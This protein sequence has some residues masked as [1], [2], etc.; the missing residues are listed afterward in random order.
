M[1][2]PGR[3]H[4]EPDR[5]H[6]IPDG[7]GEQHPDGAKATAEAGAGKAAVHGSWPEAGGGPP[8]A[9]EFGMAFSTTSDP[10]PATPPAWST[11][12]FPWT[13]STPAGGHRRRG[14]CTL[15]EAG[16]CCQARPRPALRR[17]PRPAGRDLATE[18]PDDPSTREHVLTAPSAVA[19]RR[20]SRSPGL[21]C[22]ASG[23]CS[24]T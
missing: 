10:S 2:T 17:A 18:H 6:G 3:P 8:E 14:C 22:A 15:G 11:V 12:Q 16:Q 7:V 13:P 4:R 23:C 9:P 5:W 20:W 1:R 21:S 24:L 19:A